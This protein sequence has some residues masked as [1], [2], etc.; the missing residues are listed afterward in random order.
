M[1]LNGA[2]IN[3]SAINGSG[4]YVLAAGT[5]AY[6]VT[7][8]DAESYI[9]YILLAAAA[10]YAIDGHDA[11]LFVDYRLNGEAGGYAT[12][13]SDAN[14][15][16]G[17]QLQADTASLLIGWVPMSLD[18][19]VLQLADGRMF[20]VQSEDRSIW[21]QKESRVISAGG[22]DSAIMMA[23]ERRTINVLKEQA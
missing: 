2:E 22:P 17:Y 12:T 20:T 19:G 1:Q 11:A 7:G 5:G 15:Y 14:F 18:V 23:A 4:G 13:L 8:V 10:A 6:A 21:L 9:G 3:G 16:T